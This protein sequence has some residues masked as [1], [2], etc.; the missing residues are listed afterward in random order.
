MDASRRWR[1]HGQTRS[2][3][4]YACARSR[5]TDSMTRTALLRDT[6]THLTFGVLGENMIFL[7]I[8][9]NN[10]PDGSGAQR[11][12]SRVSACCRDPGEDFAPVQLWF[13]NNDWF[14]EFK[15]NTGRQADLLVC[16][17]WLKKKNS[18]P[19]HKHTSSSATDLFG[20]VQVQP[21]KGGDYAVN[22]H[23]GFWGRFCSPPLQLLNLRP[24]GTAD[25]TFLNISTAP[26]PSWLLAYVSTGVAATN[27][28]SSSWENWEFSG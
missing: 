1:A 7:V 28:I 5:H 2:N 11:G 6:H 3:K 13:S 15:W 23:S 20:W 25:T 19:K 17:Q 12:R 10:L 21:R 14:P 9:A 4:P 16:C 27:P 22:G 26:Q 24:W 8:C 18:W